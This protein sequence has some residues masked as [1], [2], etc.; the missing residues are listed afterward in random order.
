MAIYNGCGGCGK[1]GNDT[2]TYHIKDVVLKCFPILYGFRNLRTDI[3]AHR[4]CG[5]EEET[6]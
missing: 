6:R 4:E 5:F 1:C 2:T 3:Q